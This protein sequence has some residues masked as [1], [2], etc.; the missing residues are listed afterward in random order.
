MEIITTRYGKVFS[1]K[2]M[3]LTVD[4]RCFNITAELSGDI[5]AA[6]KYIR[7]YGNRLADSVFTTLTVEE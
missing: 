2:N 5:T 3:K 4:G 1:I 7:S 6:T